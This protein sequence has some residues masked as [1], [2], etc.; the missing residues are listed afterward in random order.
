MLNFLLFVYIRKRKL[1][2]NKYIIILLEC[3]YHIFTKKEVKVMIYNDTPLALP[4]MIGIVDV[5]NGM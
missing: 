4:E 1:C 2:V 5:H 3:M